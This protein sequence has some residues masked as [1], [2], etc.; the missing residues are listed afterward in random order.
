MRALA[1]VLALTG[2]VGARAAGEVPRACSYDPPGAVRGTHEY[3]VRL[4]GVEPRAGPEVRVRYRVDHPRGGPGGLT[5]VACLAVGGTPSGVKETRIEAPGEGELTFRFGRFPP[6]T[7]APADEYVVSLF[8]FAPGPE[9]AR[10]RDATW[11]DDHDHGALA[12]PGGAL[13]LHRPPDEAGD[14]PPAGRIVE[15][16]PPVPVPPAPARAGDP[17]ATFDY[18]FVGVDAIQDGDHG[19]VLFATVTNLGDEAGPPVEVRF[20]LDP[21]AAPGVTVEPAATGEAV[22]P[23]E[24]VRVEARVDVSGLALDERDALVALMGEARLVTLDADPENDTFPWIVEFPEF[25]Y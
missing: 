18:A 2:A 20:V 4:L 17:D 16:L 22:A 12:H 21:D 13:R 3:A 5:L 9:G 25:G 8:A 11:E 23:F 15:P 6:G 1:L 10:A 7:P 24:E 19:W 14:L